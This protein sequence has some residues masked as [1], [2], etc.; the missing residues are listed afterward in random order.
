MATQVTY[1]YLLAKIMRQEGYSI[2]RLADEAHVDRAG[3]RRFRSGLAMPSWPVA[4]RIADA[5][6]VKLSEFVGRKRRRVASGSDQVG[7]GQEGVTREE[8]EEELV[9]ER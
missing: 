5:L 1:S 6:G 9:S 4:C 7:A 3:L 8:S 2:R